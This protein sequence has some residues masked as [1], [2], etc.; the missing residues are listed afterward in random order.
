VQPPKSGPPAYRCYPIEEWR[1][2]TLGVDLYCGYNGTIICPDGDCE[3]FYRWADGGDVWGRAKWTNGRRQ[4]L[5]MW[6]LYTYRL[7]KIG[8]PLPPPPAVPARDAGH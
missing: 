7:E 5:E 6:E 8:A 3:I 1:P 4:P 2:I